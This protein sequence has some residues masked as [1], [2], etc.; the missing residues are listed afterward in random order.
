[1]KPVEL[2]NL[3]LLERWGL[4]V[5]R[6][7]PR[8][9]A[10]ASADDPIHILNPAERRALRRIERDAVLRAALAGTLSGAASALAAAWAHRR[11]RV[12]ETSI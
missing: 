7:S 8:E 12:L 6:S 4:A 11:L 9:P 3:P 10:A 2:G 1:M 5:L